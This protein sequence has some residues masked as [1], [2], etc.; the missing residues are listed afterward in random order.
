M[1]IRQNTQDPLGPR[2]TGITDED[3]ARWAREELAKL[4]DSLKAM[5]NKC[6]V[7][8]C[9]PRKMGVIEVPWDYAGNSSEAVMVEDGTPMG[10]GRGTLCMIRPDEGILHTINGVELCFI[11][12][13]AVML[14]QEAA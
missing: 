4:P 1:D 3:I 2:C 5:R 7:L 9:P 8:V 13:N 10:I 14:L 12:G 11:P 6:I